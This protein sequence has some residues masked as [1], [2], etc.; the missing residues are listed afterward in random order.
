MGKIIGASLRT[1]FSGTFRAATK[2]GRS[3]GVGF[4]TN[5]G[6]DSF[7]TPSG[8]DDV[9]MGGEEGAHSTLHAIGSKIKASVGMPLGSVWRSLQVKK[10]SQ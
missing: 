8:Y 4:S 1:T 7:T 9:V 2:K 6:G 10:P 5:V 3:L